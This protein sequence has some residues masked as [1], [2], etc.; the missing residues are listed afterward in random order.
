MNCP[1]CNAHIS[2]SE[3]YVNRSLGCTK[4]NLHARP[5]L[6]STMDES[7]GEISLSSYSVDSDMFET[8]HILFK[9]A[10][11]GKHHSILNIL[12]NVLEQAGVNLV[13]E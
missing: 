6:F 9:D 12:S 8:N 10:R 1:K 3:S 7:T 13:Q 5:T 4:C 11:G 2:Y